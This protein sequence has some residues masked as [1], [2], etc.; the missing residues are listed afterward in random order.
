MTF[1][2]KI[3]LMISFITLIVA[4]LTL[5]ATIWIPHKIKW[6]Q[7]YSSLLEEERS[8]DFAIALQGVIEFFV[9]ECNNDV[10]QIAANYK[11]HF[12]KEITNSKGN[13]N[14]ENCLHFQRRLLSQFFWQL[15]RCAKPL[16]IGKKRIARD[17]TSSEAKLLKIL[18]YIGKAIEEDEGGVLYKDIASDAR[19]RKSEHY[20]GL[21]K[22]LA[23]IYH[24]LKES[25]RFIE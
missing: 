9:T 10:S 23:E 6:E 1:D 22:S 2:Q 8:L 12:I 16:A 5:I 25:K 21:N 24:V 17:F 13:I 7:L 11:A 4:V 18:I 15:N 14:K 20:R 3:S 19:V